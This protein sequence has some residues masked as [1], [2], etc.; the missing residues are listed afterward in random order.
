MR[1][2]LVLGGTAFVA[3]LILVAIPVSNVLTRGG[4]LVLLAASWSGLVAWT[5]RRRALRITLLAVTAACAGFLLLPARDPP[6]TDSLR[7]D[8]VA[9]LRRYE[10]TTYVWGGE[11]PFGIDCSGFVRRGRIDALVLRGLAR[12]DAGLVRRGIALWWNDCT[13]RALGD[14]AD[15]LTEPVT[16]GSSLDALDPAPLLPGDLAV[17]R[18]G[19]HVMAY[20]GDLTW[21]EA[22]PGIGRVVALRVPQP[23]NAWIQRPVRIVRWS[24]LAR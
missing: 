18:D 3:W 13:A 7:A 4:S 24:G 11:S 19:L 2:R 5:W 20:A 12:F 8:Y 10:G 15:G 21:I 23:G 14:G 6:D 9:G 16:E 17:T 1:S 22:D